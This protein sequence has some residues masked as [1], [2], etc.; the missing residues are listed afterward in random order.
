MSA[1]VVPITAASGRTRARR[2]E[3]AAMADTAVRALAASLTP[4]ERAELVAAIRALPRTR[5]RKR[6]PMP[7]RWRRKR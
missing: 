2:R 7:R 3:V 1:Q 4:A 6:I 5:R